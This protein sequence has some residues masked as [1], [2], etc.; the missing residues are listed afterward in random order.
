[1][2]DN[3]TRK[4]V[5]FLLDGDGFDAA[6]AVSQAGANPLAALTDRGA[7]YILDC[8]TYRLAR[9]QLDVTPLTPAAPDQCQ[10]LR[11]ARLP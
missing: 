1:M 10:L 3:N 6:Y 4:R 11:A 8:E 7:V 5:E 9:S 2:G